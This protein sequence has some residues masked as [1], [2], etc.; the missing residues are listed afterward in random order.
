MQ[1]SAIFFAL[2]GMMIMSNCIEAKYANMMRD[3][4]SEAIET[5]LARKNQDVMIDNEVS[6]LL[7]RYQNYEKRE[8]RN[9]PIC[10]FKQE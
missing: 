8:Y 1:Y 7:K 5:P 4:E 6:K 3:S 9:S 2:I 10:T